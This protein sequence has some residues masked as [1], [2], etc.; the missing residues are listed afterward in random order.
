VSS[1]RYKLET[2]DIV[3]V[4]NRW[5]P[6]YD[7]SFARF[8]R[9]YHR[10]M[11]RE[12]NQ[13]AGKV[14]DVGVG[15]GAQLPY[16][17]KHLEITGIDLSPAMLVHAH[18]RVKQHNLD[19]VKTLIEGDATNTPFPDESFNAISAAFVMSV[20][21]NPK[22]VLEEINRVL[23]PQG[24]IFILNHFRHEKGLR[25]FVEKMMAPLSSVLGW[26]PDMPLSA[27]MDNHTH[28]LIKK[29]EYQPLGIFTLLHFRKD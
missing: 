8:T 15:T 26:H 12:I 24:D 19:N 17:G 11:V 3:R 18:K 22:A 6:V 14:L 21:P 10:Q 16:Y 5:A 28:T 20:V 1:V 2:K 23:A 13:C 29:K 9:Y 4:Y 25:W 27:V 7:N